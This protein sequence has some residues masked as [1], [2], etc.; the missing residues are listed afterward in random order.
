MV[1]SRTRSSWRGALAIASALCLA[2]LL[3][4]CVMYPT[5]P[6]YGYYGQGYGYP[7]GGYVAVGGGWG[8][9]DGGWHDHG[10]HDQDWHR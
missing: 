2:A 3:G 7:P 8:W 1:R 4:G 6:D 9:H 5:Y 10:W